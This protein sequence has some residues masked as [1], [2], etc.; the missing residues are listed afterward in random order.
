MKRKE[1]EG[2]KRKEKEG[3]KRRERTIQRIS[4]VMKSCKINTFK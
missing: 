4:I 2:M 3:K 1:T